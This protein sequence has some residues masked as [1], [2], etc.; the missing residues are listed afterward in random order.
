[1]S[2]EKKKYILAQTC[3]VW[4]NFIVVV[5]VLRC[6]DVVLD[7]VIAIVEYKRPTVLRL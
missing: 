5:T 6:G 4:A 3:V 2:N 1:M 7:V